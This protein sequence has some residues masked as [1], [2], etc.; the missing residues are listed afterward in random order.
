[1]RADKA[2]VLTTALDAIDEALGVYDADDRLVAY[3]DRYAMLR[4]AIGG[5]VGLGVR[6]DELIT[7]SLQHRTIPEA[8]GR[9]DAWLTFRRRARGAYSIIRQLPNGSSYRV[10]E[11]RTLLG[12]IAVVWT[13]ISDVV[14]LDHLA[15]AQIVRPASRMRPAT[16]P[17]ASRRSH[18]LMALQ[19]RKLAEYA[20]P[21]HREIY[22]AF[23]ATC[24]RRAGEH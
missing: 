12:G 17:D 1:M 10:N 15:Q 5:D 11:R 23:A 21:I 13:D 14:R 22:L 9:E 4:S 20:D 18:E 7:S 19:W 3:N 16:D 8:Q 2:E 24:E 6:W